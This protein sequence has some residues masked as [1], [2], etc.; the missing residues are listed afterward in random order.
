M[1]DENW[2]LPFAICFETGEYQRT[3]T[4]YPNFET[5]NAPTKHTQFFDASIPQNQRFRHHIK[6]VRLNIS[7]LP[8]FGRTNFQND[9]YRQLQSVET[10]T[11]IWHFERIKKN[12]HNAMN[13]YSSVRKRTKKLTIKRNYSTK[14]MRFYFKC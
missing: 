5:T 7:N 3:E 8:H 10:N 14:K 6:T 1:Y 2:H 11:I 9:H 13:F 4:N 12:A